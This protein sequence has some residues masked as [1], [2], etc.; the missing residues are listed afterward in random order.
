GLR[1]GKTHAPTPHPRIQGVTT[2]STAT[3]SAR[4]PTLSMSPTVDWSPTS[5][6]STTAPS[7]GPPGPA[8][9]ASARPGTR[10][11]LPR[12]GGDPQHAREVAVHEPALGGELGAPQHPA[13][14]RAA[15]P[16]HA[17]LPV[18]HP[19]EHGRARLRRVRAPGRE[20]AAHVPHGVR[21][22]EGALHLPQRDAQAPAQ[23]PLELPFP[24][25]RIAVH[26]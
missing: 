21:R 3:S 10:L 15:Q 12:A 4:P 19:L 24:D 7:R 11:L 9:S 16:Q 8:P 14:H 1:S 23:I 20:P 26:P 22:L 5:N 6:N 18:H 25:A 17:R 2:P 13:R